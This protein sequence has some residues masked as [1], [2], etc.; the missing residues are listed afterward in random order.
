MSANKEWV[1]FGKMESG[2]SPL[3]KVWVDREAGFS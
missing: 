3:G 1:E 2:I